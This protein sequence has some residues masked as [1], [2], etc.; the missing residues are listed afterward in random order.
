MDD[1]I[2]RKLGNLGV[3]LIYL[4]GSYAEGKN[5]AHSDID[6]GV[7]LDHTTGSKKILS[8]VYN[9]LY[10]L[11]ADVFPGKNIDLVILNRATLELRM[12]AIS[13]GRILFTVT[14]D[15]RFDFEEK[16]MLGYADFKPLL[17]EIDQ[18]VLERTV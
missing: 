2:K 5:M 4:F 18:G 12:D 13:H 1:E 11:L 14:D 3:S 15:E 10:L 16:T 9:T 8:G 7:L 17:N 6:I